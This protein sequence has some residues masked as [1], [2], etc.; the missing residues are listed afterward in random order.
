MT[1]DDTFDDFEDGDGPDDSEALD[2]F[3]TELTAAVEGFGVLVLEPGET[4]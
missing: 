1:D 4:R 3:A 2:D